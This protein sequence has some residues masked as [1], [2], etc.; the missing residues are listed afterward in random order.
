MGGR[1][2]ATTQGFSGEGCDALAVAHPWAS[3]SSYL[4]LRSS[5]L[6]ILAATFKLH[7]CH[8]AVVPSCRFFLCLSRRS[9]LPRLATAPPPAAPLFSRLLSR[10]QCQT[11]VCLPKFLFACPVL[12]EGALEDTHTHTHTHSLEDLE[13]FCKILIETPGQQSA[14]PPACKCTM[15]LCAAPAP[16]PPALPPPHRP[17]CLLATASKSPSKRSTSSAPVAVAAPTPSTFRRQRR[18][19]ASP[20]APRLTAVGASWWVPI[21]LLRPPAKTPSPP[22][23]RRR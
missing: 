11:R 8:L 16:A 9:P 15:D 12:C 10:A 7:S 20:S 21:D 13:I 6:P 4:S 14:E 23:P 18:A 1:H 19:R 17:P 3:A 5:L 2:A 22:P